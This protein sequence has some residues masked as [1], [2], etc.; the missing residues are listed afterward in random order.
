MNKLSVLKEELE[1]D[2]RSENN[3]EYNS[4]IESNNQINKLDKYAR[5]PVQRMYYYPRPTP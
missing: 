5:K 1:N 2:D 3:F 4:E